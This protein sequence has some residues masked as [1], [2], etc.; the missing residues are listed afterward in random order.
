MQVNPITRRIAEQSRSGHRRGDYQRD[1]VAVPA[2]Y[3]VFMQYTGKGSSI[4][5]H[6]RPVV[7][8]LARPLRSTAA[9]RVDPDHSEDFAAPLHGISQRAQASAEIGSDFDE[10][11]AFRKSIGG[12]FL[13]RS[14]LKPP[15]YLM[16]VH[17][18]LAIERCGMGGFWGGPAAL[19]KPLPF[20][21]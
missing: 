19:P 9:A 2:I 16:P 1:R 12:F 6:C 21:T 10:T 11:T 18:C 13:S 3:N 4:L 17:M 8:L 14:P 20:P 15:L 5:V 7:V